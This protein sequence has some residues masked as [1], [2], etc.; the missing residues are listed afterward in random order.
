MSDIFSKRNVKTIC[1]KL[2]KEDK[3]M[4]PEYQVSL[5]V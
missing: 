5:A 2:A 3:Y 1:N 4:I